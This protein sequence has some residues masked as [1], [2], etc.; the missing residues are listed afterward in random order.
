MFVS[1]TNELKE[2]NT[3][4]IG[5]DLYTQVSETNELKDAAADF[6]AVVCIMY[7]KRMN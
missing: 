1:E 4:T 3:N 6:G 7:Q 2:I 5:R